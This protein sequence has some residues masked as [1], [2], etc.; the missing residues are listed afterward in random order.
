MSK[1]TVIILLLVLIALLLG[2]IV[3]SPI[4]ENDS[5][6]NNQR[7]SGYSQKELDEYE[8]KIEKRNKRIEASEGKKIEDMTEAERWGAATKNLSLDMEIPC[9][10]TLKKLGKC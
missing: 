9:T 5:S 7:N 1:H 10:K 2:W 8:K 4:S 6:T 3:F